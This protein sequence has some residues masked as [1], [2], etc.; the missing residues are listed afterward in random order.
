MMT[1]RISTFAFYYYYYFTAAAR[2]SN[3]H[4]YD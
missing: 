1:T 3:R 4:A 2:G